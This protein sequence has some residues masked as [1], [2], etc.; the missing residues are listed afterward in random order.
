MEGHGGRGTLDDDENDDNVIKLMNKSVRTPPPFK[1]LPAQNKPIEK[2]RLELMNWLDW[3]ASTSHWCVWGWGSSGSGARR[4]WSHS[5]P[6]HGGDI[7]VGT[8]DPGH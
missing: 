2:K 1:Y 4:K 7:S 6:Q 8:V 3:L 5:G